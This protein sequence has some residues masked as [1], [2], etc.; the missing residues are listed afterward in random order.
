MPYTRNNFLQLQEWCTLKQLNKKGFMPTGESFRLAPTGCR[1]EGID[2]Y[3]PYEI[4]PMTDEELE[5]YN[6]GK[7]RKS[8]ARQY[9]GKKFGTLLDK[10]RNVYNYIEVPSLPDKDKKIIVRQEISQSLY[11]RHGGYAINVS[12][13]NEAEQCIVE[14]VFRTVCTRVTRGPHPFIFEDYNSVSFGSDDAGCIK[15]IICIETDAEFYNLVE[16]KLILANAEQVEFASYESFKYIDFKY[17]L[18]I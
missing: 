12:L 9:S 6:K 4:R 8:E 18:E 2:Y 7:N 17:L 5:S 10:F 14:Y 1:L 3:S 13:F 15:S 11:P 16:M